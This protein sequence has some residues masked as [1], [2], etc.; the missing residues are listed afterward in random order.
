MHP[1]VPLSLVLIICSFFRAKRRK[2]GA[3]TYVHI[4]FQ[5]HDTCYCLRV[6]YLVFSPFKI[7]RGQN[8][9]RIAWFPFG[10]HCDNFISGSW[11]CFLD[12]SRASASLSRCTCKGFVVAEK[13]KVKKRKQKMRT[14]LN[15]DACLSLNSKPT[16]AHAFY[17]PIL[18]GF[19]Q[20]AVATDRN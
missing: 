4:I 12:V 6:S 13:W 9:G 17:W 1:I 14:R 20:S 3:H 18:A 10:R 7:W 8:L 5:W 19:R 11:G 2:R 16:M 15:W